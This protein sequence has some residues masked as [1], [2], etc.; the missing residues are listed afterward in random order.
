MQIDFQEVQLA[1]KNY[2]ITQFSKFKMK[3]K[4]QDEF[5]VSILSKI[6]I[7]L[8][9][10][11]FELDKLFNHVQFLNLITLINLQQDDLSIY[12]ILKYKQYNQVILRRYD[13]SLKNRYE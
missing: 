4:N 10:Q 5:Y 3:S 13:H 9:S 6:N 7:D 1:V 2:T 11:I 12:V 8:L